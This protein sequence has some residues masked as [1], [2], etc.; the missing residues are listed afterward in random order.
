MSK[1]IHIEPHHLDII[2]H[3]LEKHLKGAIVSVF[4]SRAGGQPKQFSDLDLLIEADRPISLATLA[5]LRSDFEESILPYKVDI[6]DGASIDDS[7][8][9]NIQPDKIELWR[10]F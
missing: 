4:G 1:I 9:K 7:F 8:R 5:T 2:N 10:H 6:V 3:I